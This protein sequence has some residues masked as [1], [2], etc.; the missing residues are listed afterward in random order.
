MH[1]L[2]L[3]ATPTLGWMGMFESRHLSETESSADSIL[4]GEHPNVKLLNGEIFEEYVSKPNVASVVMFTAPWCFPCQ[5]ILPLWA[6]AAASIAADKNSVLPVSIQFA[7]VDATKNAT[8]ATD[9]HITKYPT[10]K[11]FIDQEVFIYSP[12]SAISLSVIINWVNKHTNRRNIVSTESELAD[13]IKSHPLSCVA[14]FDPATADSLAVYNYIHS[15]LHFE[16]V[17]FVEIPPSMASALASLTGKPVISQ[18]PA[19]V[20][21]Y[22]HD[23][24]YGVFEKSWT[25]DN[26]DQFVRGRRLLTVNMFQPATIDYIMD[27]GLPMLMIVG[28]ELPE[29]FK[30]VAAKFIGSVVAVSVGVSMP[31]EDKLG[32]ILDV[33]GNGFPVVRI[34]TAPS[35]VHHDHDTESLTQSVIKHGRKFKP[36][37]DFETLTVENISSF[38]VDFLTG[39]INPY[40]RSEPLPEDPKDSFTKNSI[41]INAVA[42]NFDKFVTNDIARDILVVYH[43]PWCGHCRKLM[44]ILKELGATLGHTGRVLKIVKIDATRN[45]VIGVSP[46][47]YPTII[48][49][50]AVKFVVP[51]AARPQVVYAAPERTVEE[52]TKFL[53]SNAVNT[54]SDTKPPSQTED[55]YDYIQEL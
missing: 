10:L 13:F 44:P 19:L 53:H 12:Q 8:L 52:L 38:V 3:L 26:I 31:W 6:E 28:K 35:S 29:L 24:K 23:D 11:I 7:V 37:Q 49:Y 34:L 41:L 21:V 17:G 42:G 33:K 9:N 32:E 39:K 20:M 5:I 22:D 25:F 4:S 14:L 16:D 43:A 15:S 2:L 30:T 45:E 54:F 51:I 18:F 50:K 1:F 40:L 27:S 48:L 55:D 36:A 46:A 47:G